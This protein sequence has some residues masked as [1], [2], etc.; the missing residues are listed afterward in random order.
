MLLLLAH[1]ALFFAHLPLNSECFNLSQM[2]QSSF[3]VVVHIVT[4]QSKMQSEQNINHHFSYNK[5]TVHFLPVFFLFIIIPIQN[6]MQHPYS[7]HIKLNIV[8]LI[9]AITVKWNKNK[10]KKKTIPVF[11]ALTQ[12]RPF[13]LCYCVE[14]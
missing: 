6:S 5:H 11:S 10:R 2:L 8:Q 4:N 14:M 13:P 7:A 1:L 9:A 12:Y 3:F